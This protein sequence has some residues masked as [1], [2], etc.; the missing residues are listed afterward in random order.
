MQ[1]MGKNRKDG[2]WC[3]VQLQMA[4]F[5]VR[6]IRSWMH[7]ERAKRTL[8]ATGADTRGGLMFDSAAR[9]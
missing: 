3:C 6:T 8:T 1:L 2:E 4:R 9:L 7:E 5:R